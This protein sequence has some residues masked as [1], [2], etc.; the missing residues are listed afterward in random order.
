MAE[1][2]SYAKVASAMHDIMTWL[3]QTV[4]S[5][6]VHASLALAGAWVFFPQQREDMNRVL[7]R[8]WA[9][10]MV[11]AHPNPLSRV[12]ACSRYIRREYDWADFISNPDKVPW[13][14][15]VAFKWHRERTVEHIIAM[16]GRLQPHEKEMLEREFEERVSVEDIQPGDILG[17][18]GHTARENTV[19]RTKSNP[20][21]TYTFTMECDGTN[22]PFQPHAILPIVHRGKVVR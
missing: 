3:G 9:L 19:A 22:G 2:L 17:L 5:A 10:L 18:D 4:G 15:K 8:G 21:G 11:S 7:R 13:W 14:F 1:P 16:F 6:F 12:A 20:D